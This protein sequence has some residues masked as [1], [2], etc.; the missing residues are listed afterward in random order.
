MAS[1]LRFDGQVVLVTGAG[2]GERVKAEGEPPNSGPEFVRSHSCC[3]RVGGRGRA[4]VGTTNLSWSERWGWPALSRE[5]E[6]PTSGGWGGDTVRC[7]LFPRLFFGEPPAGPG[8]AGGGR[9]G[10][11]A[12]GRVR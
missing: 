11:A 1:P 9:P 7:S 5:P 2:G 12:G 3:R 4:A 10:C 8:L 6:R